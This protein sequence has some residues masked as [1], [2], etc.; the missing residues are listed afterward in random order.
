MPACRASKHYILLKE[1]PPNVAT[2][3]KL[4]AATADRFRIMVPFM[5]FLT[6]SFAT[7][8]KE[9]NALATFA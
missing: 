8:P 7:K 3:P 4:Y 2:S 9:P 1:L 6:A 5:Q